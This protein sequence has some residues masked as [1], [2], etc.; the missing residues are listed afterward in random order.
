[1]SKQRR[2]FDASYKL[3][4]VRMI[5]DQGLSVSQ[6]CQDMKLGET[7]VRRWLSQY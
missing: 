6:V 5:V 1:M 4:V 7:A 3:E 2:S